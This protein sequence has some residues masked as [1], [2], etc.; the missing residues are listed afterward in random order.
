MEFELKELSA[1]IKTAYYYISFG[2]QVFQQDEIWAPQSCTRD[3]PRNL[4]DKGTR[5]SEPYALPLVCREPIDHIDD[6]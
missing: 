5:K 4:M 2:W 1:I 3:V 6:C